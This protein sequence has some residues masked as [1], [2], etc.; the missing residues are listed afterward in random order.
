MNRM[1]H[2]RLMLA[3]AIAA[4]VGVLGL[5]GSGAEELTSSDVPTVAA[6]PVDAIPT[7]PTVVVRASVE[8]PTLPVVIVRADAPALAER[9]VPFVVASSAG[10]TPSIGL[11]DPTSCASGH[12]LL[13]VWQ[14][15]AA[16]D[17]GITR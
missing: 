16:R 3:L 6:E 15:A 13:F 4:A 10:G 5:S 12:A 1:I 14:V 8:I 11:P 2:A 9:E 7:L 17:Q